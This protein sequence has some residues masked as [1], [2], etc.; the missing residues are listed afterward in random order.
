M[1]ISL[2]AKWVNKYGIL[3]G[4]ELN[5]LDKGRTLIIR[6]GKGMS[7]PKV[8]VDIG[9]FVEFGRR[10]ITALYRNGVNEIELKYDK[11]E[12]ARII[13]KVISEEIIGF[14]II[15]QDN[16]SCILKDL[17]GINEEEFDVALRRCWLL[18][19]SMIEDCINAVKK[20]DTSSLSSIEFR[21]TSVNKL[22]NYCTRI[23]VKKGHKD[24]MK[25]P[26]S[27]QLI[28]ELERIADNYKDIARYFAEKCIKL[29][30]NMLKKIEKING[31]VKDVYSIYYSFDIKKLEDV[32]IQSKETFKELQKNIEQNKE[33]VT[34]SFLLTTCENIRNL[35]SGIIQIYI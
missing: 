18:T 30:D 9:S 21:D 7:S 34:A 3:K 17:S 23:L 26:V 2:P 12:Y 16:K 5:V 32:L 10:V 31:F 14:E 29:D 13:Q 4:D 1:S 22:T 28:R 20:S 6:P 35:A 15:K 24:Y 33:G 11:P 27:Y 25:T 19:L 8:T